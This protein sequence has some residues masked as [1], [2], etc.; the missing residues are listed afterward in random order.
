MLSIFPFMLSTLPS[1][2]IPSPPLLLLGPLQLVSFH[3][4]ISK[5]TLVTFWCFCFASAL[6]SLMTCLVGIQSSCETYLRQELA[7]TF[8]PV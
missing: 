4:K 3:C 7:L 8:Y 1:L 2:S 6:D 5:L